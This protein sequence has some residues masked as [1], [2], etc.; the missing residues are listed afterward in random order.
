LD[1]R[2]E[3]KFRLGKYF[4]KAI[5]QSELELSENISY[6]RR[7]EIDDLYFAKLEFELP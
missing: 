1:L 3:K 6:T 7:N 5:L 2:L 4:A